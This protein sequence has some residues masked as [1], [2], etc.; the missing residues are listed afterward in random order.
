MNMLDDFAGKLVAK[1]DFIKASFGGFA[2]SG[3]TKTASEFVAGSY[4]DL[5][6]KKPILIV[7]NE[8]GSRFLIPFFK[9]YGI[10][11]R[12]KDTVF[13][14]DI[15][16][17][18]EFLNNGEIDYIFIDSLTKIWYQFIADYKEKF[19]KSFITMKD[20]GNIIPEWQERFNNVFVSANGCIVF[21]G[22]GG[23]KYD[24]EEIEQD[25]G[26]IKKEFVQSGFKYKLSGETPFEPDVNIWMSLE[27]KIE[28]G[29]CSQW[30]EGMVL[31][32][33]S[34]LID[35]MTFKNPTYNDFKPIIQYL[36]G[37]EK[38]IVCGA[39]DTKNLIPG[40]EGAMY[41]KNKKIIIEEIDGILESKFPGTAS[42][43]KQAKA[44]LKKGNLGTYSDTAI[45]ALSLD[46]LTA[47]KEKIVEIITK[48]GYDNWFSEWILINHK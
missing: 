47:G 45:E 3:K 12:V 6:L 30:R 41:Y 37:V 14:Q 9:S 21:T 35:G 5:G 40:D 8:K 7:D 48:T 4:K 34:G 32:D 42:V 18:I 33:R 1:N 36:L 23:Y 26:K 44:A 38:G 15:L 2:G 31:K 39:S 28:N 22:R 20:W 43:N 10:D 19:H 17:A 27:Q 25:N 29:T 13:M 24:L 46:E 16:T 11:T